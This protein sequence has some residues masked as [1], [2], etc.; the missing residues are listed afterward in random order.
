MKT[1]LHSPPLAALF[2]PPSP[3]V[4]E[5]VLGPSIHTLPQPLV[6]YVLDPLKRMAR[7]LSP[8]SPEAAIVAAK[9]NKELF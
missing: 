8:F 3:A 1:H 4:R 9:L 7:L 5:M 6:D 2:A